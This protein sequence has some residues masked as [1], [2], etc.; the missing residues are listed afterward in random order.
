MIQLSSYHLE[1]PCG[2]K[3]RQLRPFECDF[4]RN[5]P[6]RRSTPIAEPD[7]H[8]TDNAMHAATPQTATNAEDGG[9]VVSGLHSS[10]SPVLQLQA[11]FISDYAE[12]TEIDVNARHHP[13]E[14]EGFEE[15]SVV[16]DTRNE[17]GG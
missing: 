4:H 15:T 6:E 8:E 3:Q 17:C 10:S 9:H 11:Q 5:E 14:G 2:G 12:E 1:H 16:A 7:S 13:R